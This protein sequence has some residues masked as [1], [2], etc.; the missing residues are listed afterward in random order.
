MA[1][2]VCFSIISMYWYF[3]WPLFILFSLVLGFFLLYRPFKRDYGTKGKVISVISF[4]V[5]FS[6]VFFIS[7]YPSICTIDTPSAEITTHPPEL[8]KDFDTRVTSEEQAKQLFSDYFSQK[9]RRGEYSFPRNITDL[10]RE[11]DG[12]LGDMEENEESYS[13]YFGFIRK[14]KSE[15]GVSGK[16]TLYEDG[17]LYREER[18]ISS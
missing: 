4:V 10:E 15:D 1:M 2:A 3:F 13:V 6:T 14:N 9:Y 8:V 5:I 7:A 11:L 12:A 17:E 16:Y 18:T